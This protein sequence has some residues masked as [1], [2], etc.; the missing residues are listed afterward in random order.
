MSHWLSGI[1]KSLPSREASGC[2]LQVLGQGPLPL[3]GI[4]REEGQAGELVAYGCLFLTLCV[5]CLGLRTT[6]GNGDQDSRWATP[7]TR[8]RLGQLTI[9]KDSPSFLLMAVPR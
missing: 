3:C 9:Y 6:L 2:P 7:A 8:P 5:S 4:G 1:L